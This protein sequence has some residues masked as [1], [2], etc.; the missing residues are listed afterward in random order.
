MLGDVNIDV[1]IQYCIRTI[2]QIKE[3]GQEPP[4]HLA[5]LLKELQTIKSKE[6]EQADIK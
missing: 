4:E 5:G 1:R 2:D 3:N 6:D